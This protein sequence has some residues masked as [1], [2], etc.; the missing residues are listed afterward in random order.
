[1][2]MKKN[3]VCVCVR[4]LLIFVDTYFAVLSLTHKFFFLLVV[5][6]IIIIIIEY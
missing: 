2:M 3:F 6:L 1:M 5:I 4:N